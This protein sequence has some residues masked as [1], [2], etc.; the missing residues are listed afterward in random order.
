MPRC[1]ATTKILPLKKGGGEQSPGVV[2]L[3]PAESG[4]DNPLKAPR[5]LSVRLSLL[6]RRC[7]SRGLGDKVGSSWEICPSNRAYHPPKMP[8]KVK[9]S[10]PPFEVHKLPATIGSEQNSRCRQ[11]Y[12]TN[13]SAL[14]CYWPV[15]PLRNVSVTSGFSG[16]TRN[17][18]IV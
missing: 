13:L 4:K 14:L 1:G 6:I 9:E 15:E 5:P 8:K 7:F 11:T 3:D 10:A 18:L 12:P 2:L 16:A 17:V